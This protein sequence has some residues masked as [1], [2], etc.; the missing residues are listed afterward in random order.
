VDSR[1]ADDGVEDDVGMRA[2]EQLGQ[3]ASY[4]LQGGVDV[5]ERRR[6][7]G[8]G[9]EL[10]LRV[11]LHDLDR[12]ATDRARCSEQRDPLHGLSVRTR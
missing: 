10:E 8:R 4:L 6:A 5:V 9:A 3:V 11:R 12:L 7:G 2:V 1:E